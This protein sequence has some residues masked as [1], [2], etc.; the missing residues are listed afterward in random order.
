MSKF[1][2]EPVYSPKHLEQQW[3]NGCLH[4][5]DLFCGCP[6]PVN[7]LKHLLQKE[8]KCHHSTEDATTS[9]AATGGATAEDEINI[10]AGDLDLLFADTEEDLG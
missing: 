7:H 4:L 10:D 5:H 3:I 1:M 6:E 2:R 9:T 8:E